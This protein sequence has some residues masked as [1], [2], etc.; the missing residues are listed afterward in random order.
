M[1]S[2]LILLHRSLLDIKDV[3]LMSAL[4]KENIFSLFATVISH[5][6][7]AILLWNHS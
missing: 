2:L 4:T 1:Y 3:L 5:S 6:Q 7:N